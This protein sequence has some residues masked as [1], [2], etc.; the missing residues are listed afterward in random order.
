MADPL[1]DADRLLLDVADTARVQ[2][3]K[4]L[5]RRAWDSNPQLRSGSTSFPGTIIPD[6]PGKTPGKPGAA[7]QQGCV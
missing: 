1:V 4:E 3:V 5:K 7:P 6:F 2:I